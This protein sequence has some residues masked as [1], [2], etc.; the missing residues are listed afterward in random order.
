[1]SFGAVRWA[2]GFTLLEVLVAL[3]ILAV[4]LGAVIQA[5]GA[6]ARN[7]TV[8]SERAL[9]AWMAEDLAAD[10]AAGFVGVSAQ[11]QRVTRSSAGRDWV[12]E[13]WAEALEV[14]A[15][16]DLPPIRRVEIVVMDSGG[17]TLHRA[18]SY[19]F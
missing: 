15:P 1:M 13:W 17:R 6:H 19:A 12:I 9:A 18:T 11:R 16:L 7:A 10:V 3:V 4:A 5:G 8:L 14:E 2:R